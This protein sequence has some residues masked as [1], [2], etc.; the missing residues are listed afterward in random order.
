[1]IEVLLFATLKEEAGKEKFQVQGEGL[2]IKE[3]KDKMTEF[4]L[5]DLTEVMTAINEEYA[6]ENTVLVKGDIVA[7]IPPVSGG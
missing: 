1:M 5:T 6:L 7:F 3:L 4:G 2:T